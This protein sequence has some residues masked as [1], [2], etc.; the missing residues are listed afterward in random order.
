M[1]IGSSLAAAQGGVSL[2]SLVILMMV[3]LQ[4]KKRLP[5]VGIVQQPCHYTEVIHGTLRIELSIP[6]PSVASEL[7]HL[8]HCD[9]WW[10]CVNS[11]VCWHRSWAGFLELCLFS[12]RRNILLITWVAVYR[13]P[14]N[15]GWLLRPPQ[16]SFL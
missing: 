8:S 10:V 12:S 2:G 9:Y 4:A 15:P 14:V 11:L 7:Q 16:I 3:R 13:E 5:M 6:S 1:L